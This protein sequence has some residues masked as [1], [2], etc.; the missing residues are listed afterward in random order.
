M[1]I[2]LKLQI[3][4][5]IHAYFIITKM[6]L[7]WMPPNLWTDGRTD[8]RIDRPSDYIIPVVADWQMNTNSMSLNC[9]FHEIKTDLAK[10]KLK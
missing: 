6:R 2:T 9:K 8:G 4:K 1:N 7:G 3:N 10:Q 5:Q